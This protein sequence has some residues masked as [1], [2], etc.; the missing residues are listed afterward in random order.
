VSYEAYD[1]PITASGQ[2]RACEEP[3]CTQTTR[4][5]KPFCTDHVVRMPYAR[6]LLAQGDDDQPPLRPLEDLEKYEPAISPAPVAPPSVV[7]PTEAEEE[8]RTMTQG[9]RPTT[10]ECPVCGE[11]FE[12]N[13]TGRLKKQCSRACTVRATARRARGLPIA[14]A[15]QPEEEE[16]EDRV[17]ESDEEFAELAEDVAQD[18]GGRMPEFDLSLVGALCE[19]AGLD[20][21]ELLLAGLLEARRAARAAS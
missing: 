4:E 21:V 17:P 16:E 10:G 15:E 8:T 9:E 1:S 20:P 5:G 19:A 11:T 18:G 3:G 2:R 12:Q 7:P 6:A 13:A 14:D